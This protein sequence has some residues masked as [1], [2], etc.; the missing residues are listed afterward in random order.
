MSSASTSTGTGTLVTPFKYTGIDKTGI[1]I[2]IQPNPE[3]AIHIIKR[4]KA[5]FQFH[6]GDIFTSNLHYEPIFEQK[7]KIME[8]CT[9]PYL[10]DL[11]SRQGGNFVNDTVTPSDR[12]TMSR[13]DNESKAK[14]M[15]Q[16]QPLHFLPRRIFGNGL[17]EDIYS[18]INRF[19]IVP[20]SY[21]VIH[22]PDFVDQKFWKQVALRK[23]I[24]ELKHINSTL[25][26]ISVSSCK[27]IPPKFLA[28]F[29]TMFI[30]SRDDTELK[31]LY[32]KAKLNLSFPDPVTFYEQA[33]TMKETT[34]L[35][36]QKLNKTVVDNKTGLQKSL[37]IM[38]IC[39]ATDGTR[40][41]KEPTAPL[42][43]LTSLSY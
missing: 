32:K 6:M 29:Q 43:A 39:Y 31:D 23:C 17:S 34:G 33:K 27:H 4:I 2:I 13:L 21:L 25:R 14:Y 11:F 36:V 38:N 40:H 7:C 3:L 18:N 35:V 19:L 22:H 20:E 41:R 37:H 42:G 8:E 15:K 5:R 24:T 16:L 9:T 1:V 30:F 28:S 10:Q 12:E 26:I